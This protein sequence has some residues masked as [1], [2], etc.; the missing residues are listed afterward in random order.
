MGLEWRA[1]KVLLSTLEIKLLV[2]PRCNMF[3]HVERRRKGSL[4][5]TLTARSY[6]AWSH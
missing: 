4:C 3:R 2:V 6:D 1:A 5:H